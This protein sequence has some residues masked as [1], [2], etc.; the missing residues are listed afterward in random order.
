MANAKDVFNM[1]YRADEEAAT[2]FKDATLSTN[3]PGIC[4]MLEA[5]RLE[6]RALALL[7][8]VLARRHL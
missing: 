7:L 1:R 8:D 3:D 5:L 2:W 6:I 4:G